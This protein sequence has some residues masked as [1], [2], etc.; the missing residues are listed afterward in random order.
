MTPSHPRRGFT[1]IELLVVIA[2]IAILIGL[3]LPAVQ[4]VREAAARSKCAN[5]LKQLGIATHAYHDVYLKFPTAGDNGP[6]VNCCS[7][8][9][10]R[11]DLFCWTYHILP[12][13]EQNALFM[14]VPPDTTANRNVVRK[15]IVPSYYC[16]SRRTPRLY[17]GVAKCDYAGNCGTTDTNGVFVKTLNSTTGVVQFTNMA[18]ITDGTSNTLMFGEGRVH[19]A[20]MDNTNGCCSDN[21][22][23]YTNGWADDVGRRGTHAPAPDVSDLSIPSGDVDGYFG[24]SHPGGMNACLADGSVRFIR[25]SVNATTFRNLTIRNDGQI[26]NTNDL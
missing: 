5:N 18:G 9:M 14:K 8:D 4:K 24:S 20:Y 16:P 15:G 11:I 13:M 3:L 25:F 17:Q 12:F 10:G 21:E 26:I 7:A 19:L 2:I 1:L 6:V 23:C 22:D